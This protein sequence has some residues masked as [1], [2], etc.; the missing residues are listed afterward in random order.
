MTQEGVN[1]SKFFEISGRISE[2]DY[3]LCFAMNDEERTYI[4]NLHTFLSLM[5][6]DAFYEG[7]FLNI[8]VRR[9]LVQNSINTCILMLKQLKNYREK[10]DFKQAELTL[11]RFKSE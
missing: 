3:G 5:N 6:K 8:Q 10:L 2:G 11:R 1:P 7:N 4:W 9:L